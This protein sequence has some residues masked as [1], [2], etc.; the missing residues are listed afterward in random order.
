LAGEEIG[1]WVQPRPGIS[2]YIIGTARGDSSAAGIKAVL[3]APGC[4]I[5]TL[6]IAL[7]NASNPRYSFVCQ[8]L[9]SVGIAGKL[10]QTERLTLHEVKVQANY[11]ARWAQPFLG[12]GDILVSIPVGD[13]S[14]LSE[15][16]HFRISVPDFS[17]DRLAG[18]PDHPGA[19]QIWATDKSNGDEVG[20]L[21]AEGSPTFKTRMG[22]LKIQREYPAET[23]FA[24]CALPRSLELIRRDDVRDPCDR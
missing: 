6:D 2:A 9:G 14:D 19:I 5:Q 22:G 13:V 10:V 18:T 16:Y 1:G 17:R 24:P 15:D 20:Q 12:L 4:A 3:Y 23:V 7:S 8:P 11:I 21:I